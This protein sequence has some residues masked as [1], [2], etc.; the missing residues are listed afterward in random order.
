MQKLNTAMIPYPKPETQQKIASFLDKKVAEIDHI[1][2][3]TQASIEEYKR[4]K[5]SIITEAVTK[6][7]DPNVPMKDSGIEWIGEIP[8]H[9]EVIKLKHLGN[10]RSGLSNKKPEDFGFGF[11]FITYKNIYNN[12]ALDETFTD[13]VNSTD[14]DRN[15]CNVMRGDA[16]FTGSSE[17]IEELGLSSVCLNTIK[18]ATFNGFCIRFRPSNL[19]KL[20][21]EYIMYYFRSQATREHLI[22]NDN[23][24][25]RANLSQKILGSLKVIIPPLSEQK[26]LAKYLSNMSGII[27]QTLDNKQNL[28]NN[29]ES[30]KKSLIYEVVTGKKEVI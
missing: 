6:G 25:T 10:T 1:I 26:K 5:Q 3:K 9:W 24:I 2:S 11:P 27:Q 20:L 12:Y 4:Y 29:L 14:E 13:L 8:E 23:S 21:P 15:K 16:F 22:R 19:D 7:L 18:S 17:T 28:I 30:Y